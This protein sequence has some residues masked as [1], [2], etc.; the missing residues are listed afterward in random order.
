MFK[1]SVIVSSEKSWEI[2]LLGNTTIEPIL[3]TILV[4]KVKNKIGEK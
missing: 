4:Q 3:E 1:S 2:I